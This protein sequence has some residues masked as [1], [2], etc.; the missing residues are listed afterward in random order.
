MTSVLVFD[1]QPPV[2]SQL[3]VGFRRPSSTTQQT[4]LIFDSLVAPPERL[5][6]GSAAAPGAAHG[7]PTLW[8]AKGSLIFE[9][10]VEFYVYVILSPPPN[11]LHT[12]LKSPKQ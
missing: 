10:T 5:C 6:P 8:M 9:T 11:P 3:P 1:V 12:L 7:K 2:K 4:G